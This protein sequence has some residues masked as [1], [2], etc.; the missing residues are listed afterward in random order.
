MNLFVVNENDIVFLKHQWNGLI[1]SYTSDT[2]IHNDTFQILKE[3][4]TEKSRFYHT[5]SHIKLLLDLYESLMD[6]IQDHDAIRFSIWFHDI[7]YDPKRND[8]EEESAGLASEML[9][10]LNVNAKTIQSVQELV[11]ATKNHNGRT[12][13]D[14]AKLFLDM[15]LAI[16]G[17]SK[18]IYEEYSKAIREEYAWVSEQTYRKGRVK[19]LESFLDRERVY[20]TT[21]MR[22]RF[23]EQARWNI[24]G[25]IQ[26]LVVQ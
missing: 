6:Q 13:S 10:D 20:F 18:E 7:V 5:F 8:N 15:D 24:K 26:S 22:N 9:G 4:Y 11:L 21:V 17:M 25:E 3:K 14:D 12:L 23:E 2:S 1:S 16:L 19:I